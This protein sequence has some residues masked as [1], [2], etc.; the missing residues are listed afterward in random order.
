MPA[1]PGIMVIQMKEG[2]FERDVSGFLGTMN[3]KYE[4]EFM[5]KKHEGIPAYDGGKKP[6]WFKE[7]EI[8]VG[9]SLDKL[10]TFTIYHGE[11]VVGTTK[12]KA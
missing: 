5:S 11:E 2:D 7:H 10:I 6:T 4:I 12:V 1:G 8:N 3:P 9:R